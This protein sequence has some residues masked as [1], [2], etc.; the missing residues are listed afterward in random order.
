MS[1]AVAAGKKTI[2]AVIDIGWCAVAGDRRLN[3]VSCAVYLG[4][5]EITP[6]ATRRDLDVA[7]AWLRSAGLHDLEDPLR[8]WLA[9]Y[10][11][12]AVDDR[13]LHDW[14]RSVLMPGRS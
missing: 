1:Q 7:R 2:T 14:C 4:S 3:P 12:F 9:A 11:A 8:R 5:S 6:P 10:W 13:S